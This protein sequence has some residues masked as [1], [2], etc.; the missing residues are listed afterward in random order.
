MKAGGRTV[1]SGVHKLINSVWN[2]EE[3][4]GELKEFIIVPVYK[5]GNKQVVIIEACYGYRSSTDHIFCIHQIL[6]KK[7]E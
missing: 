4:P 2:K 5:K 7:W 1:C 6:E 3:L